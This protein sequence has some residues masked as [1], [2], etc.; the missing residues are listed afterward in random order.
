MQINAKSMMELKFDF[1]LE[2]MKPS[3]CVFHAWVLQSIDNSSTIS[4][5][6]ITKV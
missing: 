3:F 2:E 5:R 1:C 4:S 6:A